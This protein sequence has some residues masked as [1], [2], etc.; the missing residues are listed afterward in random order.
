MS[1]RSLLRS[2]LAPGLG[3]LD[4]RV[5]NLATLVDAHSHE[6]KDAIKESAKVASSPGESAAVHS[7]LVEMHQ[8]LVALE[9]RLHAE[10][11]SQ[12][13]A[14]AGAAE[15]QVET[16][17]YLGRALRDLRD[18]GR[19]MPAQIET[20]DRH[21]TSLD[22]SVAG[23]EG[24]LGVM[25]GRLNRTIAE[26]F[27]QLDAAAPQAPRASTGQLAD[28]DDD[29]AA[30]LNYASSHRGF[31]AQAGL[32]F[33]PPISL[34]FAAGRVDVSSV[35]ER[36]IEVPFVFRAFHDLPPGSRIL[37]VGGAESTI[38]FALACLGYR[39][40]TIDPRGYPLSH[41]CLSAVTVPLESWEAEPASF[42]AIVGL[43]SI[44]HF[45]LGA[46]Q[47]PA[48]PADAD[49]AAMRRL[50]RLARP[51]ARL[52][53]TVPFGRS[54]ENGFQ[55]V[56]DSQRLSLLLDDWHVDD[57]AI[58]ERRQPQVWQPAPGLSD[59]PAVALV[60]AHA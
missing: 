52:A 15:A 20:V 49:R 38:A 18:E 40:T 8:R 11:G 47:Q 39:V 17:Q 37:D 7:S 35:N 56:Y 58:F 45:G 2:M 19:T 24:T 10:T 44:E 32:W 1:I 9:Q 42:D 27:D 60:R 41:P 6:I 57:I 33:N 29:S 28:L 21:L 54:R 51:G 55:R 4:R 12:S 26:R 22:R 46:Y 34:A 31:A 43:S 59:H 25:I 3:L 30:W 14:L 13:R 16:L 53:L 5:N 36:I 23:L 48:G 50:R